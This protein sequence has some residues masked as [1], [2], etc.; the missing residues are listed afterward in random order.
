MVALHGIQLQHHNIKPEMCM[1]FPVLNEL[2][3]A[4]ILWKRL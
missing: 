4:K 1:H 3:E 2:G